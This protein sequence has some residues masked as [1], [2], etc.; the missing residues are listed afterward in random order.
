[1]FVM[2]IVFV[3]YP[4]RLSERVTLLSSFVLIGFNGYLVKRNLVIARNEIKQGS[5]G[6]STLV[7]ENMGYANAGTAY[8]FSSGVGRCSDF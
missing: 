6:V 2:L 4:E 8:S 5:L 3:I 1:M 7:Y